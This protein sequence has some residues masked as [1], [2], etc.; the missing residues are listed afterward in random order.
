MFKER[1]TRS[2]IGRLIPISPIEAF[3]SLRNLY[4]QFLVHA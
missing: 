1:E 3:L 2:G 4:V